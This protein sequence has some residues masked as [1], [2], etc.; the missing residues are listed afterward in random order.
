MMYPIMLKVN[1][2]EIL[3]LKS[4]SKPLTLTLIINWAIKLSQWRL[5][6]GSLCALFSRPLYRWICR[7]NI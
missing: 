6:P 2:E 5:L 3:R 7:Q 1:F 4:N